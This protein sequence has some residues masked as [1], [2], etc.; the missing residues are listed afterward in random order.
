MYR[1]FYRFLLLPCHLCF[2]I[3][4]FLWRG[5]GV[6]FSCGFLV[7][8]LWMFFDSFFASPLVSFFVPFFSLFHLSPRP[9]VRFSVMACR[10]GGLLVAPF[11]SARLG[12][13]GVYFSF[14]L[15]CRRG[16]V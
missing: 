5:G 1:Y 15:W 12:L 2:F 13:A 14:V 4:S 16:D 10:V 7:S 6:C 11:L 8:V 3:F 9:S